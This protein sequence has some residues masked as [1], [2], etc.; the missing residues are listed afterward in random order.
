M[1]LLVLGG[2]IFVGRAIV[3]RA[4]EFGHEVTLF[5]R[6]KRGSELFPDV[7]RILGD[8]DGGLE[9][10]EGRTWDAVIDT[11]GYVPR[12][13]RQ[14]V[15]LLA[16]SAA[17]YT[18]ISTISVYAEGSPNL[19]TETSALSVLEDPSVEEVTGETYGGLKALCE[20]EVAAA[21]PTSHLIIRPGLIVGPNDP[22]GRFT[23]WPARVNEGGKMLAPGNPGRQ[24]QFIDVRDLAA[25]CIHMAESSGKGVYNAAGPGEP[26]AFGRLL[27]ACAR[28]AS[29]PAEVR[30]IEDQQLLSL[31]VQP[32]TDLPMWIP[33][34]QDALHVD[35]SAAISVGL[36]H[37]SVEETV[38][39]TL[40]WYL[41]SEPRPKLAGIDRVRES[42]LL[43]SA[44]AL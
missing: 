26:C 28:S 12:V 14:S 13:V 38:A 11:C 44:G 39:D 32:W 3:D 20:A 25:W 29:S 42:E 34:G 43:H 17:L 22:T 21:F 33:T 1:R 5:H 8:R 31:G 36:S 37:R 23:Y 41:S 35:N 18:F 19:R 4:L 6:G 40:A 7:E 16:G 9:A 27:E 24:V 30:W 15:Q 10:L 2:T